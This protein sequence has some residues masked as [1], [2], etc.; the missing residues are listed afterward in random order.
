MATP[1]APA[2]P[3][4]LHGRGLACALGGTL[5]QALAQLDRMASAPQRCPLDAAGEQAYAYR[6]IPDGSH[7]TA[8]A[9]GPATTPAPVSAPSHELGPQ[10][11]LERCLNQIE[12]VVQAAQAERSGALLL[13][14]SS[15]DMGALERGGAWQRDGLGFAE[16]IAQRLG[17]S[18]PLLTVSTACT[19]AVN[20]LQRARQLLAG[21]AADHALVLGLEAANRYSLAGFAALQL[22]APWPAGQAQAPSGGLVLG[23]AVA[24]LALSTRPSRW[25]LAGGAHRVN[26]SDPAGP[27]ASAIDAA[28]QA[29]LADAGLSAGRI[30]LVKAHATGN[31]ASDT[32]EGQ[33]LQQHLPHQP[34]RASL[35]PWLGHT[36]GASAAAELALLTRAVETGQ[37]NALLAPGGHASGLSADRPALLSLSLGFGGGHGALVLED[38]WAGQREDPHAA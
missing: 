24:A 4:Y 5:D 27:T 13:A 19:S 32:M 34:A 12:Q 29:A 22:L 36:Q 9:H 26:G 21:G 10:A 14:S 18:G 11:W 7:T 25:R 20:A 3:V 33:L 38:Q 35:K 23:E 15:F 16:L 8:A 2:R 17:W 28:I 37:L 31:P 30:G 1:P 6:P